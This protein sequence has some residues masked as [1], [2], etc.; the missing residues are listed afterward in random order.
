MVQQIAD[1]SD[2][3]EDEQ[4][5]EEMLLLQHPIGRLGHPED[6]ANGVKFLLS[7]ESSFMTGS[8]LVIDGGYTC[9]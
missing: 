6:I 9:V 1:V 4:A 5:L 7:E 2:E 8:E 3:V